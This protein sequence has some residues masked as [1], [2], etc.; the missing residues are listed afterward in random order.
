MLDT[1]IIVIDHLFVSH[2][3]YKLYILPGC[4]QILWYVFIRIN[5]FSIDL[6]KVIR[7]NFES[8]WTKFSK[9]VGF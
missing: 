7:N 9:E 2:F 3:P 4:S 1:N 6:T 8:L 5:H